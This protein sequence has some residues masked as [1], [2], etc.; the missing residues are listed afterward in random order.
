MS[1]E[2][3]LYINSDACRVICKFTNLHNNASKP[4]VKKQIVEMAINGSGIKDQVRVL[5][6]GRPSS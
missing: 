1:E 5:K 2:W 6:S 4:G 3:V